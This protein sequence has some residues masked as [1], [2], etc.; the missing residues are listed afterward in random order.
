MTRSGVKGTDWKKYGK[1]ARR[2]SRE[3]NSAI[4]RGDY[5]AARRATSSKHQA[6]MGPPAGFYPARHEIKAVDIANNTYAFR[7]PGAALSSIL[8]NGLLAGASFYNRVGSRV[9]LRNVHI[10]G[11]IQMTATSV[12]SFLR[13]ILVYDRQ[14][15]GALFTATDLL[16]NRDNAGA[17]QT[18]AYSEINLDNRDRFQIVRDWTWYAPP[19]TYTA[20]V[21]TNGPSFPGNEG[22]DYDVNMFVK[23]KGLGTQYKASTGL[24]GDITT[25]ALVLVM[26]SS[27]D[28]TWQFQGSI[29]TRFDDN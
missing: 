10:R 27:I 6:S 24:I 21:L 4:K 7:N 29:R 16:Q 11:Q 26:M 14:P 28:N 8:C 25:G 5:I 22:Q 17:T 2:I 13:M 1:D 3:V 15:N 9:E 18:T 19:A 20:G 23:L 12:T